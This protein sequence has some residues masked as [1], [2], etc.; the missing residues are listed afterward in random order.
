[1]KKHF[2]KLLR[3]LKTKKGK[4][5][6]YKFAYLFS[7]TLL[8]INMSFLGVFFVSLAAQAIV[9]PAWPA[10]W[11]TPN[12]CTTDPSGDENPNQ[13]DIVGDTSNPAVG[14]ASDSSFQYFRQR[15]NGNP[16]TAA[17]LDKKSWVV[18]FQITTPQYQFLGTLNGK[19]NK[20]QLWQNTSPAGPVDFSPLLNDPAETL[21]WQ[22][23][24]SVYARVTDISGGK[25]YIDWAIPI[26]ELSSRGITTSATKFF[27]TSADANNYNK[28]HLNCYEAIADLSIT[29][30][31]NPDPVEVNQALTY[32]ISVANSGPDTASNV[33][34]SDTLPSDFSV[35]SVTPSTG[36]C[37]DT[38]APSIQCELGNLANAASANI[39]IVGSVSQSGTITNSVSVSSDTLDTNT[40]NNNAV[41]T[42][43]VNAAPSCGDGQVNQ[44][45]EICDEGQANGQVCTPDYDSSCQY[46]SSACETVNV[47]G[48]YCGDGTVSDE[49][50]CDGSA[51]EHYLCTDSCTLEYIPY[52]GDGQINQTSE[53]CEGQTTQ[54]CTTGTGYA[55]LQSC[56]ASSCTW[57]TECVSQEFCGDGVINDSE[58][59]DSGQ[60]NG[61]ACDPAYGQ[62]CNYC[63]TTCHEQTVTGP[64]CGDEIKNGQEACDGSDGV[65]A[66]Q[67]CT[68]QCTIEN[69]PY[70][71][72]GTV[73]QEN[74]Q[75]DDGNTA[76]GDG[77]SSTCTSEPSTLIVK[78]VLIN[79]NGG[80]AATSSFSFQVN[81][82][83]TTAFEADGQNDLTV[84][85]GTYTVT[86]PA[87]SGYTTTYNNCAG[88]QIPNGGTAT[89]TI[90]NDDQPATLRVVKHVVN[91]NGGNK[92][93]SEF[94]IYINN[95]VYSGKEEGTSYM[96]SAGNYSIS[97]SP[98]TGYTGTF[99]GDCDSTGQVTLANGDNKTCTITND[100]IQPKLTVTKIVVNN[101]NGTKTV[102]DFPLFIEQIQVTSGAP[103]SLN[104]GTY[105]VSETQ[106]AGYVG[107]IG[108]ACATDGSVTL[109]VGDDKNCTITNDDI[110]PPE[111]PVADLSIVKTVNNQS[112]NQGDT[113]T[114]TLTLTNNGPAGATNIS[115]IDNLP[116]GL[117]FVSAE[118]SSGTF[119]GSTWSIDSLANGGSTTLTITATV[120]EGTGGQTI[121]NSAVASATQTDSN[122]DNSSAGASFTV[123]QPPSTPPPSGGGGGGGGG[124][125]SSIIS[126]LILTNI[127]ANYVQGQDGRLSILVTWLTN[128]PATSRVIYDTVSHPDISTAPAPNYGYAFSTVLDP[129]KITGHSVTIPDVTPG[130]TYY[131]RP[132]SSASP[133]KYGTEVMLAIAGNTATVQT[134]NNLPAEP[135][136]APAV[137]GEK[138]AAPSDTG[139]L[140]ETG[141][142]MREFLL[143]IYVM[144]VAYA[145]SKLLEKKQEDAV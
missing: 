113:I 69:L 72:D 25:Y 145:A 21:V 59:C 24:S 71:G 116:G 41:E 23:D 132:L 2:K 76:S 130:V 63:D 53:E 34:V 3:K 16:G 103:N 17:N 62:N 120:N 70:C 26:F 12:T 65:G 67:A 99:S 20:V 49:E 94:S 27:A 75:C 73:N 77:C 111:T 104:A 121:I 44:G 51:P 47:T 91:D 118:P 29:K 82:G 46:C 35:S 124:G 83:Q 138:I 92:T 54:A 58:Q 115:V 52:C 15:I 105:T 117:T 66:H 123:T 43:T 19:D 139:R 7:M 33:L 84:D 98:M 13:I 36:S 119:S 93:A 128:M 64:Y 37:S 5:K 40:A 136:A 97:E 137:L 106:Q 126:D 96:L 9:T 42:T 133:E 28:D 142:S 56:N 4:K 14:F 95:D 125:G 85:A 18:L 86:E 122:Q 74:E 81:Q 45:T 108:G 1:M 50:E 102:Q 141:F 31:D 107:L 144:S 101:N 39:T 38:S 30:T 6:L 61:T 87:V 80:T 11:T 79:D 89:C 55:G 134:E 8:V 140:A 22:G 100:D 127:A 10:S 88:L 109:A 112:P 48:P 57:N 78:K 60:A 68:Q 129:N 131:L 114:Y 135:P 32:T 110:P 143:L 90:T